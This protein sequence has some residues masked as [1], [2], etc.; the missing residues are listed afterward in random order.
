MAK[1]RRTSPKAATGKTRRKPTVPTTEPA[2]APG[3]SLL[4]KRASYVEAVAL[5]ERGLEALQRHEFRAAE[6]A[7][8]RVLEQYPDER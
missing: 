1:Q 8:R 6:E 5:Y 2:P 3:S 7:L 4:E